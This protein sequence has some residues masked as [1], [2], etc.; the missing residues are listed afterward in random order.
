M[1]RINCR[2]TCVLRFTCRTVAQRHRVTIDGTAAGSQC[3][4]RPRNMHSAHDIAPRAMRPGRTYSVNPC[5]ETCNERV[6][7]ALAVLPALW[8]RGPE[9]STAAIA[10]RPCCLRQPPFRPPFRGLTLTHTHA[11]SR[12]RIVPEPD[13]RGASPPPATP[14]PPSGE[15]GG[16]SADLWVSVS[17]GGGGNAGH[18]R[19]LQGHGF[20]EYL[21]WAA[22]LCHRAARR[23]RAGGKPGVD[24]HRQP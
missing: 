4:L 8:R 17:S 11:R 13:T 9:V 6:R 3:N 14:R 1:A 12:R 15:G 23:P 19:R 16:W 21:P 5:V 22:F 2:F 18:G 20:A 10:R 7:W 24:A